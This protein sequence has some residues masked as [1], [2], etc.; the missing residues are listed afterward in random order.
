M[1]KFS[2][3]AL[4][5]SYMYNVILRITLQEVEVYFEFWVQIQGHYQRLKY[6]LQGLK[7]KFS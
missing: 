6:K 1:Q 3:N 7:E 5:S 4:V 2:S